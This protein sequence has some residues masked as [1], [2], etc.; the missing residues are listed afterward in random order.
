[1]IRRIEL[2]Q[3][4]EAL[5]GLS[6]CTLA[7]VL[8]L[9]HSTPAQNAGSM[10]ES[11]AAQAA[12]TSA[13]NQYLIGP[14]D[15][16][17]IR[18]FNRPTLSRESVRVDERGM[19]RLPLISEVRAECRTES[20]L[21]DAIGNTYLEYLKNPNVEVFIKDYQSKPVVVLGAVRA[22][23]RFQLQRRVHL[24]ELVSLAGGLTD[25]AGGKIQVTHAPGRRLCEA[26]QPGQP[27][28]AVAQTDVDVDW[29]DLS[30]LLQRSNTGGQIPFALP[31]DTI[32]LL[33]A[34]KAF[35]V[36]NVVKP[37]EIPLK[38]QVTLSQAIA[39]AGGA[40]PDSKLAKVRILRQPAAGGPKGEM[41]VDLDAI[42]LQK[43]NDI[44]LQANDIVEVPT[45]A[46]KRFMRGLTEGLIPGLARIPLR[47][48]H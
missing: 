17:D 2:R 11:A 29:Y 43:E 6:V 30:E 7:L 46:K 26:S 45:S 24:V 25:L 34:N 35:I 1:M 9:A 39:M 32:N 28:S 31:G 42:N 18:I 10:N 36:G 14:G 5:F 23:G 37:I 4:F 41:I 16:L 48:I 22:P 8:V 38:E 21:A 15:V 3:M 19:I 13:A 20:E 47:V 44:V 33:E 27:I 12:D 40:L